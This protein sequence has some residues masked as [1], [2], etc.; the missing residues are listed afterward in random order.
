MAPPRLRIRLKS[1]LP[2]G[3]CSG[4][5][6]LRAIR[7]AAI[8]FCLIPPTWIALSR[9]APEQVPDGSALFNLMRNLG[10]AIGIGLID[11]VIWNRA[12]V[13][14]QRLGEQVL[15]RDAAAADFVG[16]DLGL[17]PAEPTPDMLAMVAPLFEK[18]G[19]V[20]AINEAWGL[21][22]ILTLSVLLVLP[23]AR[24]APGPGAAVEAGPAD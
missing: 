13:H 3:T 7:G 1:A 6:R 22:A 15:A 21:V 2:S 18:A 12:P 17:V 14:A 11:T 24:T 8:M 4:A 23:L 16:I 5:R 20:I 10:G 9:L 19:L